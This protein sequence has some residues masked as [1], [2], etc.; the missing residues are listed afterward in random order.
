VLFFHIMVVPTVI[1]SVCGLKA[2]PPLS[3]IVTFIV[4]GVGVG[5]GG[6]GFGLGSGVGVGV[7]LVGVGV[8]FVLVGV[9]VGFALVGVGLGLDCVGVAPGGVDVGE[10]IVFVAPTVAALVLVDAGAFVATLPL[11]P[12]PA[13]TSRRAIKQRPHK[14]TR[15]GK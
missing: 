8:G 10:E 4:V 1:V 5:V 9:G 12:Q 2:K 14:A 11:P 13:S 15:R 6:V 7:V 3:T